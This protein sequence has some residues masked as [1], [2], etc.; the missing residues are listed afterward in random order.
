MKKQS[1]T[2]KMQL[3]I[4]LLKNRIGYILYCITILII[5]YFFDRFFQMLMFILFFD[6]LQNCFFKRFHAESITDDPIKAVRYCKIITI[7]VEIVYLIFCNKLDISLY[8]NLF[9]IFMVATSN[10]LLQFFLENI[11]IRKVKLSDLETL[12]S[13]CNK[14]HLTEIATKRMIMRY[15]EKKKIKEIADIEKV[16]IETIKQSIRR[17]KRK[18]HI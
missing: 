3:K 12:T 11:V 13:L 10:A 15:V 7:A 17:S 8:N 4:R 14:A 6:F 16:E 18:I 2:K 1:Q 5:A 9:I